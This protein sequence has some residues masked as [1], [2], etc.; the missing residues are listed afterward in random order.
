MAKKTKVKIY[1]D[2]RQSLNAAI[3]FERGKAVNLRASEFPA[4]PKPM[5]P[6]E[7]RKVLDKYAH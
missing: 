6:A 4:P 7:I 5:K 2:M 3:A 1:D